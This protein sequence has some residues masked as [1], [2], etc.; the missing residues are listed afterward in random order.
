MPWAGAPRGARP[1]GN[2]A[3]SLCQPRIR[4]RRCSPRVVAETGRRLRPSRGQFP[5][6]HPSSGAGRGSRRGQVT[7]PPAISIGG[8]NWTRHEMDWS[9]STTSTRARPRRRSPPSRR[10]AATRSPVPAAS[11]GPAEGGQHLLG[12]GY[13]RQRRP[14]E[15]FLGQGRGYRADQDAGQG[16]GRYQVNVNAVAFGWI[17][18][19]LTE[20]PSRPASD[21]R[22]RPCR[23]LPGPACVPTRSAAIWPA[24]SRRVY[25]RLPLAITA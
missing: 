5:D 18:T 11:P 24:C 15:L 19:R 2:S 22:P 14:G 3:R 7:A 13:R 10:P 21:P 16:M 12:R 23:S 4:R 8:W 17:M 9:S 1:G 25:C 20:G 6:R